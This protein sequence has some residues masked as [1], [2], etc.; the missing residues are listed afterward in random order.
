ME[1]DMEEKS[2]LTN[3]SAK[4]GSAPGAL[5]IVRLK[6]ETYGLMGDGQ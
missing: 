6:R 4:P 1:R 3:I 2:A 5:R